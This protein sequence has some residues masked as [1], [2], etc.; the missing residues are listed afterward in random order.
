MRSSLSFR[1]IR[2][3]RF[4]LIPGEPEKLSDLHRRRYFEG[5]GSEK[6]ELMKG[7]YAT[8][9]VGPLLLAR[10]KLI[11]NS[12]EE[13]FA[14]SRLAQGKWSVALTPEP[15]DGTIAGFRAEF[16]SA[17]GTVFRSKVCDFAS[18]GNIESEDPKLFNMFF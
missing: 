15:M 16:R 10:S 9:S 5:K 2:L 1:W 12:E 6:L 13:M 17:D 14:P 8:V 4:F 7:Y 18:A 11:G 3:F